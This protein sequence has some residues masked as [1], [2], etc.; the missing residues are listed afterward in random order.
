MKIWTKEMKRF[1]KVLLIFGLLGESANGQS[2]TYNCAL[3]G[4]I[5]D[6]TNSTTQDCGGCDSGAGYVDDGT[7]SACECD[8][9][10]GYTS[11]SGG[12]SCE[13]DPAGNFDGNFSPPTQCACAAT[14]T[15]IN[16]TGAPDCR[17][18]KNCADQGVDNADSPNCVNCLTADG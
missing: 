17:I 13:C 1:R 10:L 6:G 8:S 5:Q 12:G 3:E 2:G 7:S 16:P 18:L 4:V 9:S 14:Y 15:D 11:V